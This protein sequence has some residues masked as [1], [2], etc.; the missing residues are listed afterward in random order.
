MD[1]DLLRVMQP[2][3]HYKNQ[4]NSLRPLMPL[5]FV[6]GLYALLANP[7]LS[8]A[9]FAISPIIFLKSAGITRSTSSPQPLQC[10]V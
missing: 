3:F 1:L 9:L 10:K 7:N 6:V 8:F 5:N 2:Y 4:S